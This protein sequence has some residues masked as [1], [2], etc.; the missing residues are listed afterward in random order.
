MNNFKIGD[1]VKFINHAKVLNNGNTDIN[2]CF[3]HSGILDS[4]NDYI[5]SD[6][7]LTKNEGV[8][9]SSYTSN[10]Y[11]IE[12]MSINGLVKMTFTYNEIELLFSIKDIYK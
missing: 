6:L 9:I 3:K 5:S 11:C 4:K 2:S 12:F 10:Y 1:K 7:V 8:I